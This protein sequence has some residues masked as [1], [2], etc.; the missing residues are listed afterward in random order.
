M[1]QHQIAYDRFRLEERPDISVEELHVR[2][3]NVLVEVDY[4]DSLEYLDH[5][6]RETDPVKQD[7]VVLIVH[8]LFPVP[9]SVT[10]CE[11]SSIY[12]MP[13]HS[14]CGAGS[15]H[16]PRPRSQAEGHAAAH[17]SVEIQ[18]CRFIRAGRRRLVSQTSFIR[19]TDKPL[20]GLAS[21]GTRLSQYRRQAAHDFRLG[22]DTD[23]PVHFFAFVKHQH[24]R[25]AL[26]IET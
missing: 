20:S 5:V 3:G 1:R 15:R 17:P 25:D 16:R 8:K 18:G 7:I 11:R 22:L 21:P 14:E 26:D 19:F 12:D 4:P 24:S 13:S 9:T 23:D 6:L 2:P 10:C